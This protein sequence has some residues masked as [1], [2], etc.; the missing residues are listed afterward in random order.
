MQ[1]NTFAK[2]Y[3]DEFQLYDAYAPYPMTF[4]QAPAFDRQILVDYGGQTALQGLS[5][6]RGPFMFPV[7]NQIMYPR[8]HSIPDQFQRTFINLV[9]GYPS[10]PNLRSVDPNLRSVDPQIL[11]AY[12]PRRGPGRFS[13]PDF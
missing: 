7:R 12:Y 8:T 4:M 2:R 3:S 1:V 6:I 9:G 13:H 10:D 11:R 5:T